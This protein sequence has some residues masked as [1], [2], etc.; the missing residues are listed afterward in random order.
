MIAKLVETYGPE[1][2][3]PDGGGTSRADQEAQDARDWADLP[4]ALKLLHETQRTA[5]WD[6]SDEFDAEVAEMLDAEARHRKLA[7]KRPDLDALTLKH[8]TSLRK[9]YYLKFLRLLRERIRA[10]EQRHQALLDEKMTVYEQLQTNRFSMQ[11]YDMLDRKRDTRKKQQNNRNRRVAN[12]APDQHSHAKDF[13]EYN[14]RMAS[15][16]PNRR[17]SSPRRRT[18]SPNHRIAMTPAVRDK[19]LNYQKKWLPPAFLPPDYPTVDHEGDPPRDA[20]HSVASTKGGFSKK[21]LEAR[22]RDRVHRAHV[23]GTVG[24]PEW[25]HGTLQSMT[26]AVHET[27][28]ER[29]MRERLNQE[30]RR[31]VTEGQDA[32]DSFVEAA[33]KSPARGESRG[34]GAGG[35]PPSYSRSRTGTVSQ[36]HAY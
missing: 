23:E 28:L 3:S 35:I 15:V 19:V 4:P 2:A 34:G 1:P 33:W 36:G 22:H 6:I 30:A 14:V 11:Y 25:G 13:I 26:G 17:Q 20:S 24:T 21:G 9:L 5:R 31:D 12:K 18:P 27:G 29:V 8:H 32:W 10:E 7:A 16:S